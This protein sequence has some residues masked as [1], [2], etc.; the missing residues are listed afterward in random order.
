MKKRTPVSVIM[1]KDVITLSST[2]DLMT[3]EKIFKKE[4]I[5][6][7]PVV[8]GNEIKGMLS[9]TDLLRISFADAIDENET[10]V[11]TVVYNMFTIDQV[12]AKNLET[13]NSS[14]TIKEVAEILAK[15]EFHALPVV[16]DNELVGIVT[17]TDLIYYLLE[18]F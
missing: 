14:T 6:H 10:D 15:K 4:H 1:T 2:D 9:Y 18:Q 5:R 17:T 3:A 11:D 8:S 12:M 16:D 13:V 7:I